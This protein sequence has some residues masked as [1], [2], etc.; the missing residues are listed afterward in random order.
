M[1]EELLRVEHL[2]RHFGKN[3]AVADLSFQIHK[4]EVLGLVGESGSGKTTTGRCIMGLY[5][6]SGGTVFYNHLPIRTSGR[7]TL[8]MRRAERGN[9]RPRMQMIFQDPMASLDPRMTVRESAA[10]GLVI[11][12]MRDRTFIRRRVDEMLELVGLRPEYANRYPHEFSG[13]QRQRIGI[14]RALIMEPE[15]LIA[16]EP[17]SALDVSVQAQVINLLEDLQKKLGLTVLF[18]AHD[19]SVVKYFCDR[20]GVMHLGRLVELAKTEE[21]FQTP[22]H[23]YTQSLLSAIP[24]PD[25]R[26]QKERKRIPY[27]PQSPALRTWQ[28]IRPEHFLLCSDEERR[29]LE[30]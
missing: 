29:A 16:D 20:I 30:Q 10:E 11:Q 18:I 8:A 1:A 6:L 15:L 3:E 27:I 22:L 12:G 26:L 13:G 4:G 24:V 19:L 9:P 23:P 28:E 7:K 17:V 25:P 5:P 21:L 2:S 14:A